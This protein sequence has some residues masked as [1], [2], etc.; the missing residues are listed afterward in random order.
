MYN[1]LYH[2]YCTHEKIVL[3]IASSGIVS[4]LLPGGHISHFCLQILLNIHKSLQCNINKN[5]ELGDLLHQVTLLIWDEILIQY[6]FCF[7][8]VDQILQDIWSNNRLFGDWLIIMG[9]GFAQIFFV[10][11]QDIRT[12]IVEACI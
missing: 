11:Y 2:S 6:R 3:C 7:E 9:G 12:T 5:S 8:I 1:V 4:L 10:V